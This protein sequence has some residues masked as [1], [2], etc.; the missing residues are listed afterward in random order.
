MDPTVF[1]RPDGASDPI[2]TGGLTSH[3]VSGPE[4]SERLEIPVSYQTAAS[5]P[6]AP[7]HRTSE[8]KVSPK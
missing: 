7:I 3:T 5:F 8:R 4:S 1:N 2:R 6:L